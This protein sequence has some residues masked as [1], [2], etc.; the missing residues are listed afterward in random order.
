MATFFI[1]LGFIVIPLIWIIGLIKPALVGKVLN[2]DFNRKQMSMVA[3][4]L[5]L[6]CIGIGGALLPPVPLQDTIKPNDV[7]Q[8]VKADPVIKKSQEIQPTEITVKNEP[9][10]DKKTFGKPTFDEKQKVELAYIALKQNENSAVSCIEKQ[11]NHRYY[12]GCR[13]VTVGSQSGVQLFIYDNQKD[14]TKRFYA[15]NGTARS[16]YES[17]LTNN[18][19][20][21]DFADVFGLPLPN[22]IMLDEILAKFN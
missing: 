4:P 12:L 13:F 10:D 22:D 5:S 19:I 1:L 17:H 7:K 21:G 3:V 15:L 14:P 11:L 9:I 6:L 2:K 16:T 20:F 8:E 18:P